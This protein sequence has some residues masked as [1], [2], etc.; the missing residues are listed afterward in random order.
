VVVLISRLQLMNKFIFWQ[1]LYSVHN[2][3]YQDL[4]KAT[5]K[6]PSLTISECFLTYKEKFL[7]HGSYCS[8]MHDAR[9]II[10]KLTTSSASFNERLTVN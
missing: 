3:F 7:V 5:C 6:E 1:E 10:D 9:L 8:N 4:R 2:H